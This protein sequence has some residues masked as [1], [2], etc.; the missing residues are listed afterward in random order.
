MARMVKNFV[1]GLWNENPTFRLMIGS[2][3]VGG[4]H[5]CSERLEWN[6]SLFV[7]VCPVPDRLAAQGTSR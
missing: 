5:Q 7:F 6:A 3:Y 4:D 2:P 1:N